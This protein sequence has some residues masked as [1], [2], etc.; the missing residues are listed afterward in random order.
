MAKPYVINIT[1]GTGSSNVLNG[2]YTASVNSTG[3]DANSLNP[4][5]IDVTSDVDN[6]AFTVSA[7]G[8]LVLHVSEDGTSTGTPVVGAKFIRCDKNGNTYGS[9]I[10]TGSDGNATFNNVPYAS[11]SAPIIYYKQTS[12]DG[13]HD[14]NSELKN[15]T[16]TTSTETHEVTNT[17][18]K[19]KTFT[20]KDANYSGL[21]IEVAE[22]TLS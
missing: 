6:Y 12:S 5:T 14:F 18:A 7:S 15:V 2:N 4:S 16:L 19:L 17:T 10:T 21:N 20:L 8:T 13:E 1:N 11:S 9:E 3:Y 22:I